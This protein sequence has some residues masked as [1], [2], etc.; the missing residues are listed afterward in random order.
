MVEIVF[1]MLILKLP[2]VYLCG[3]VWYAIKAEPQPPDGAIVPA[4]LRPGPLP[5]HQSS[6][7]RRLRGGR[8]HGR[9]DRRPFGPPGIASARAGRRR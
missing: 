3:V 2:I 1:L 5:H 7:I 8:P 6:R 9:P 4:E